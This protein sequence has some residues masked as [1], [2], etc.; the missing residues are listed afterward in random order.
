[1]NSDNVYAVLCNKSRSKSWSI[2]IPLLCPF[3]VCIF[4]KLFLNRI[5]GLT[6]RTAVIIVDTERTAAFGI[7]ELLVASVE[8]IKMKKRKRFVT[9]V[10]IVDSSNG[11]VYRL[12]NLWNSSEA[13]AFILGMKWKSQGLKPLRLPL[14]S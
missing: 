8:E 3:C 7:V 11:A 4:V 6:L 1:M 10:L 2:A 13:N 5:Y 9:K 14:D 12:K